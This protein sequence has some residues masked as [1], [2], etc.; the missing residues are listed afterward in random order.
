MEEDK[1]SLSHRKIFEKYDINKSPT[2]DIAREHSQS[3]S[4]D[5]EEANTYVTPME[6]GECVTC[7]F[8]T[9]KL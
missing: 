6:T 5:H 2:Y 8:R 1:L 4:S 3:D 9:C 7:G